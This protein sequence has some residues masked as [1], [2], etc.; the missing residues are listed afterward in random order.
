MSLAVRARGPVHVPHQSHSLPPNPRRFS[1][2][3]KPDLRFPINF[4]RIR[5]GSLAELGREVSLDLT[6]IQKNCPRRFYTQKKKAQEKI[7][8]QAERNELN[9][10]VEKGNFDE[11]EKMAKKPGIFS[12]D[13]FY[14]AAKSCFKRSKE[15][16]GDRKPDKLSLQDT[17]ELKNVLLRVEKYLLSSKH[18]NAHNLFSKVYYQLGKISSNYN[19]FEAIYYYN[20]ALKFLGYNY[21][22]V[23]VRD[24][25]Q[26]TGYFE[27]LERVSPELSAPIH[28]ALGKA[29][30]LEGELQV[31]R[32][33]F[34][35]VIGDDPKNFEANVQMGCLTWMEKGFSDATKFFDKAFSS[36]QVGAT[37]Q[38]LQAIYFSLPHVLCRASLDEKSSDVLKPPA[39]Y[40]DAIVNFRE[41]ISSYNHVYFDDSHISRSS[42]EKCQEVFRSIHSSI[43]DSQLR[44]ALTAEILLKEVVFHSP[45]KGHKFQLPSTLPGEQML[46]YE[47]DKVFHLKGGI[48]AYG[49]VSIDSA[50]PPKLLYRGTA[51]ALS[52][53]GGAASL[54]E[55]LDPNGVGREMF[56][57]AFNTAIN[58]WLEKVSTPKNR[59]RILGYSQGASLA[60]LT[61]VY[62]PH[63]V[64]QDPKF[65]S[66]TFNPPGIDRRACEDWGRIPAG[67]RPVINQYLVAGDL[68]SRCGGFLIG[69][70]YQITTAQKL[71]LLDAHVSLVLPQSHWR[72]HKVNVEK[73]N[74]AAL[75]QFASGFVETD[76]S[77]AV[78]TFL[79][80]NSLPVW[81][82][83]KLN[84]VLSTQAGG[85]VA[86]YS[87]QLKDLVGKIL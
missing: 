80:S 51:P 78:Y 58:P 71:P 52:R 20:Q 85:Y 8:S 24:L 59:A 29:A 86:R 16:L 17:K 37:E 75:R 65:P 56:D 49:M 83:M 36:N 18:V 60:A 22:E 6:R 41:N 82:L 12:S 55:D 74:K 77:R 54:I 11:I 35:K 79:T 15:L 9:A 10:L 2:R 57:E 13:L 4:P 26:D 33:S 45:R 68:V 25:E 1:V 39:V 43:E 38:I 14:Y 84:A 64:S 47:V 34:E 67:E 40:S 42:L 53:K 30:F 19:N 3:P 21:R 73:D 70:A 61:T 48:P 46:A 76:L 44:L 66:I 23:K 50:A 5:P 31:A 27:V 32:K 72:M 87:M 62:A 69:D 81:T 63:L 7:L 28:V